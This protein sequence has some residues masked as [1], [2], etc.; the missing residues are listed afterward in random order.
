MT[1]GEY[2]GFTVPAVPR[3]QWTGSAVPR[4][5]QAGSS[6][7][8]ADFGSVQ[9]QPVFT[10]CAVTGRAAYEPAHV[11]TVPGGSKRS[12]G[13]AGSTVRPEW[14]ALPIGM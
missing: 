12:S 6:R 4:F 14:L 1:V 3:I 2:S 5:E 7:F 10:P 11:D 8:W 13:R 9:F